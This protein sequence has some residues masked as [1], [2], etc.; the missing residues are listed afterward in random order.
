MRIEKNKKN[1]NILPLVII[2]I[3]KLNKKLYNL[4]IIKKYINIKMIPIIPSL[5]NNII[6]RENLYIKNIHS[7]KIKEKIN[8]NP[9]K[10]IRCSRQQEHH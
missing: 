2:L 10:A 5:C 3:F 1:L 7:Q 8:K 6:S 9:A 4:A